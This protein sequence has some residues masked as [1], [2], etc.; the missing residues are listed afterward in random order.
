MSEYFQNISLGKTSEGM[1]MDIK[2]A[3]A[4]LEEENEILSYTFFVENDV[5]H[6]INVKINNPKEEEHEK[7][8]YAEEV[9]NKLYKFLHFRHYNFFVLEECENSLEYEWITASKT[10]RYFLKIKIEW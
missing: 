8:W 1:Q 2:L 9:F 7:I 10:L 4:D 5:I 3:L 6:R